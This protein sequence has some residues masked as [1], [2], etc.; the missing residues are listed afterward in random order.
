MIMNLLDDIRRDKLLTLLPSEATSN[1]K[2]NQIVCYAGN[3][4][5]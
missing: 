2:V 1:F 4:K 5:C 3:F